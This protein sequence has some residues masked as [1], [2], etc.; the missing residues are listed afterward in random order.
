MY[1]YWT[2]PPLFPLFISH[3][4]NPSPNCASN[5]FGLVHL[6]NRPDGCSHPFMFDVSRV[7]YIAV[8]AAMNSQ[9]LHCYRL[10]KRGELVASWAECD[11]NTANNNK[12][13]AFDFKER[14][15]YRMTKKNAI[16]LTRLPE[17]IA[18]K[19]LTQ[20]QVGEAIGIGR[21]GVRY[22]LRQGSLKVTELPALADALG[23]GLDDLIVELQPRDSAALNAERSSKLR[24][25]KFSDNPLIFIEQLHERREELALLLEKLEPPNK[26]S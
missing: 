22:K 5:R 7:K 6:P 2:S 8:S 4:S 23:M 3:S 1:P 21:D 10:C 18:K 15:I 12:N 26:R 9:P 14:R 24:K 11:I 16:D 17:L 13:I 19:G 25:E 20:Q